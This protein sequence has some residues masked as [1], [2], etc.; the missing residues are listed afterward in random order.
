[1]DINFACFHGY[2][3]EATIRL[4]QSGVFF[5]KQ[6]ARRLLPFEEVGENNG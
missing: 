2:A 1:V 4:Y 5:K 6:E 3:L